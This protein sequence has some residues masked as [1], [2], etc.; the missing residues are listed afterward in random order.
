M[1]HTDTKKLFL[2]RSVAGSKSLPRL[3]SRCSHGI[4]ECPE[5]YKM[6]QNPWK[7]HVIHLIDCDSLRHKFCNFSTL[8]VVTLSVVCGLLNWLVHCSRSLW[9][10]LDLHSRWWLSF[11]FF[12]RVLV[13]SQDWYF[14]VCFK[15]ASIDASRS[16]K[17][18]II[19]IIYSSKVPLRLVIKLTIKFLVESEIIMIFE[20]SLQWQ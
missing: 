18:Y 14:I 3:T 17:L 2:S 1:I 11:C 4:N 7:M 12:L 6:T 8:V 19:W 15:S 16:M 10:F 5:V 20:W 9:V 13:S